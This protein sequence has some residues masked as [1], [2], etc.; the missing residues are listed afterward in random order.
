MT[1]P[2]LKIKQEIMTTVGRIVGSQSGAGGAEAGD[3]Q[4][5]RLMR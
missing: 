3:E 5:N 2:S 4:A 1:E